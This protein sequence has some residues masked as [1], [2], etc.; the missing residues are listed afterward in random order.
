M[1]TYETYQEAKIANPEGEVCTN[2]DYFQV[3]PRGTEINSYWKICNPADYCMTVEKFLSDGHK[4]VDG[5]NILDHNAEIQTVGD[6][7]SAHFA[8]RHLDVTKL[9]LRAAALKTEH[10]QE[11]EELKPKR[12]RVE[13][14]KVTESIFDLKDEFE[15]GCLYRKPSLTYMKIKDEGEILSACL[16]ENIYRKEEVEVDERQE[17]ID[18][19]NQLRREFRIQHEVENFSDY[20]VDSGR[21]KLVDGE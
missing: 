4:F 6:H 8:N 1:K 13:Y 16:D 14:V 12:T 17:F 5:D 11:M 9:V 18:A 15:R 19:Y 2:G 21:F 20:L 3:N 7:Y 10:Q